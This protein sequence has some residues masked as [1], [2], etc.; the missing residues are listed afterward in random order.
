M[1]RGVHGAT[2]LADRE[3]L[4]GDEVATLADGFGDAL[5]EHFEPRP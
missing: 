1:G 3:V 5:R 4:V 2:A